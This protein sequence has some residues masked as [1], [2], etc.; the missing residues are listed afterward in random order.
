MEGFEQLFAQITMPVQAPIN[1]KN[2][3]LLFS[4]TEKHLLF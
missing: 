2:K 3:T 1:I 4:E